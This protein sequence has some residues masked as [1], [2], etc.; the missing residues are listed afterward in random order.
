MFATA[1]GGRYG[2]A[3][4]LGGPTRVVTQH[5]DTEPPDRGNRHGKWK[6]R[7]D[8]LDLANQIRPGIQQIG[9]TEEHLGPLVS[10]RDAPFAKRGPGGGHCLV[11]IL[12]ACGLNLGDNLFPGW[13]LNPD[14]FIGASVQEGAA[15]KW[16]VRL[17]Q[18]IHRRRRIGG[19]LR[20]DCVH[21]THPN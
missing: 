3:L 5:L 7:L 12:L 18:K 17:A 21:E 9:K 10:R 19:S 8:R 15:D 2:R 14:R 11:Q 13:I 6:A 16:A 20:A 4:Q 1:G